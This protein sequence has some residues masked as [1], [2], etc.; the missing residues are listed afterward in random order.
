MLFSDFIRNLFSDFS[1]KTAFTFLEVILYVFF[2]S[3]IWFFT[4]VMMRQF[5]W[6]WDYLNKVELFR[7]DFNSLLIILQNLSNKWYKFYQNSWWKLIL[8]GNDDLIYFYCKS[9]LVLSWDFNKSVFSWIDCLGVSG[10][11]YLSWYWFILKYN[12]LW[13]EKDLKIWY[14]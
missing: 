11:Q 10:Q 13:E 1:R 2:L 3:I 14:K 4:A 6:L 8:S 5:L 7:K 9:W 12:L